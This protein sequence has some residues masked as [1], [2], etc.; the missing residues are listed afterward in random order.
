MFITRM[1][2]IVVSAW[3]MAL[4]AMFGAPAAVGMSIPLSVAIAGILLTGIPLALFLLLFQGAPPQTI[5][6]TL[7]D[8]EHSPTVN[9]GQP[10]LQDR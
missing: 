9:G 3:L 7:Y 10:P 4:L 6:Q 8:T 2:L 5:G 1:P